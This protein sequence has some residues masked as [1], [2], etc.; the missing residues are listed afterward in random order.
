MPSVNKA[1]VAGH[2]GKDPE[3]RQTQSGKS[4]CSF[5]MATKG[6]EDATDWHNIVVW[7]NSAESCA[8]YLRKGA[9]A[10]VD[11]RIQTRSWEDKEGNKRYTTE[12][13]ANR[14]DFLTKAEPRIDEIPQG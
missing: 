2:L 8:K 7:G 13:V 12:I 3:L 9:S 4:V 1:I 14:V 11:G 10:L 6:H 5:T